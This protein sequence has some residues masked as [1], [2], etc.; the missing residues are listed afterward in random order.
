MKEYALLTVSAVVSAVVNA[1]G[2]VRGRGHGPERILV[3]KIDHVGDLVLATPAIRALRDAHPDA[4]ID[5]LVALG[6][7]FVLAGNSAVNHVLL[8]DSPWFRRGV[9]GSVT[10][11]EPA[12]LEKA[13]TE[14][15]TTVVEL[16]G[17]AA[18]LRLPFRCGARRR[19]DR[20]TVRLR[21]WIAGRFSGD[22]APRH[23]VETNL[24]IVR[25]LLSREVSERTRHATPERAPLEVHRD[26]AVDR[27][28]ERKLQAA[29][30]NPGEPLV[31]VH[32][33]ASWRPRAWDPARFAAVADWI[34]AHYHAQVVFVGSD[35]ERDIEASVRAHAK[36]GRT[37]WLTGALAWEELHAL[38]SRAMFFVGNDSGP[39]HVAAA[40]GTPSVVLF[41]PQ[42]PRRF[43]PWSAR[44][45][46]LH[47]RAPCWPCA[48]TRCVRPE[49]PCVNDISI[50]EV[51]A[52][53]ARLLGVTT[54]AA[55]LGRRRLAGDDPR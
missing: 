35:D 37:F 22:D 7:A 55:D 9:S 33:G 45:L 24:E 19:V 36:G 20:G 41:G 27:S 34:G 11:R 25:P 17:D 39:A 13:V 21:Q 12:G 44:I 3:V 43:G 2:V 26:P 50:G 38:L 40:A 53:I 1:L 48:Q 28:L 47:H 49:T 5:V 46:V 18:T 23:E 29:G 10:E 4:V 8:Y 15:Y 32:A 16:R 30:V 42:D 52:A 6:S 31:C 51:T 54:R 14:R